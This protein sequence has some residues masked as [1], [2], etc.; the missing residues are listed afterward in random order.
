MNS[1]D[2]KLSGASA[3]NSGSPQ[4]NAVVPPPP[5]ASKLADDLAAAKTADECVALAG[6]AEQ[7]G[8]DELVNRALSRAIALDRDCPAA[9]L[10]LAARALDAGDGTSTFVLLEEARRAGVLPKEVGPLHAELATKVGG[11]V[12]LGNYFRA[13]G[14]GPRATADKPLSV[15]LVTN[16]FPPQELGGYG[17]MMWEFAEGLVARGHRVSI[18]TSDLNDF[19]Q[20]PTPDEREMEAR[21]QRV[22]RMQGTWVGGRPVPVTDRAELVRR[23]TENAARIQKEIELVKPDLVL[24]GNIDFL[25]SS[26]LQP[27][28][29]AH[30]PVLHALANAQPGYP[31]AEQPRDGHYWVAPCSDWN[32]E[33]FARAGFT[34]AHCETLY[35][36]ARVDRFFRFFLPDPQRLR[37]CYASLVLPYKG[38]DTLVDA[39]GHLHRVGL[40]FSAEIAGHAPDAAFLADLKERVQRHGMAAKVSFTGFLDRQRLGSLFARSNVLVFPSVFN[41]PFGISQVEALAAGLVVVSSG[42]GG[43]KEIIRDGQDGLLFAAGNSIDLAAKLAH[44]AQDPALMVHLQQQGQARATTFSVEQAVRRIER[45]A[46]GMQDALVAAAIDDLA[47]LM[48]G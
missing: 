7:A 3:S 39:L 47:P 20:A 31:L 38:A 28:L 48:R 26:I 27:A 18:L 10:N 45:L 2:D 24:A 12:Q 5:A 44:L 6:A 23:L 15:L 16:L 43:A 25:G 30:I 37:I 19:G 22:L 42:T 13:I 4:A 14:R 46:A 36:G 8:T 29:R 35:P 41:E 33:V 32:G 9:L 21:V 11:D 1:F 40:D 17:R 34:P